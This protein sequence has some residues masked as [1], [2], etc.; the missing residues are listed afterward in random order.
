M[1]SQ[2]HERR[3]ADRPTMKTFFAIWFLMASI[4]QMVVWAQAQDEDVVPFISP[5]DTY[6]A[7]DEDPFPGED[8]IAYCEV[9]ANEY[10]RIRGRIV[11]GAKKEPLQ[12]EIFIAAMGRGAYKPEIQRAM[13]QVEEAYAAD[14]NEVWD[15][16]T[17]V[18]YGQDCVNRRF[19]GTWYSYDWKSD[20]AFPIELDRKT[21]KPLPPSAKKFST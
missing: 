4:V 14:D 15:L 5:Y 21:Q 20:P 18:A 2:A 16:P 10:N 13:D 11:S 6:F 3:M 17:W 7:S 19:R 1:V 8:V 9:M 12:M